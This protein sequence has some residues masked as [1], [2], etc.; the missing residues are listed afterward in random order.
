M[1]RTTNLDNTPYFDFLH[2]T[3][4]MVYYMMIDQ[5]YRHEIIIG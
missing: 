1:L 3:I 4:C 2:H 5:I